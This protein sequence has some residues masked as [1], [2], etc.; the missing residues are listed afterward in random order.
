MLKGIIFSYIQQNFSGVTVF[1]ECSMNNIKNNQLL[2]TSQQIPKVI[3]D[4]IL[5][6]YVCASLCIIVCF[7]D[8]SR[9]NIWNMKFD[10]VAVYTCKNILLMFHIGHCQSRSMQNFNLILH[11][12]QCKL[13]FLYISFSI[14]KFKNAWVYHHP[15]MI[16]LEFPRK[17]LKF[18]V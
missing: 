8:N 7:Y 10:H 1:R 16:F 4:P 15:Q 5:C 11:L 14:A 17:F 3:I 6:M 18:N 9:K 2:I 12:K 13:L